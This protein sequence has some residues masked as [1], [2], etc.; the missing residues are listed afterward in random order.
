[1]EDELSVKLIVSGKVQGVSFRWFT[2]QAAREMGL[3]GYA[4]NLPDGTVEVIAEGT[5]AGLE[6][7]I[8]KVK[9]GSPFSHVENV[10]VDWGGLTN[11]FSDFNISS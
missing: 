2:V 10:E 1:M 9:Q 7:L 4:K 8:K 3:C 11:Q 6:S 5:K